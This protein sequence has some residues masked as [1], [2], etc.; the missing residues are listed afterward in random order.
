MGIAHRIEVYFRK[1][2]RL[3]ASFLGTR[4]Q[5]GI[6][7]AIH[8]VT[9]KYTVN[10]SVFDILQEKHYRENIYLVTIKNM[11]TKIKRIVTIIALAIIFYFSEKL[12]SAFLVINWAVEEYQRKKGYKDK[13]EEKYDIEDMIRLAMTIPRF[14]VLKWP[15][16]KKIF[17]HLSKEHIYK[18][19]DIRKKIDKKNPE[20]PNFWE[21]NRKIL[22]N[23]I[24]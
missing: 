18:V 16:I 19:I 11:K 17:P 7:Y 13:G 8:T 23:D 21:L 1:Y 5:F 15:H 4:L 12:F 9:K 24:T 2:Q 3:W 22:F 20:A 10:V 6:Y 14:T